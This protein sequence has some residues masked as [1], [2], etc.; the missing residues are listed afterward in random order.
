MTRRPRIKPLDLLIRQIDERLRQLHINVDSLD[1]REK[2]MCLV[3]VQHDLDD[4]GVSTMHYSGMQPKGRQSGAA[5]ERILAYF[6]S[7]P[8]EV[9]AGDELRVVSGI[10]E[11]GRRIRELRREK[12][13]QIASG[14]SSDAFSGVTLK[15]DQYM[16]VS[17]E[18]DQDAARRWHIVNRIRR[19]KGSTRDRILS[20]LQENVGVV[21]TTEELAYVAK[22][23][24]EFGRRIR[25]LRTEQGY[26]IA[27]RFTG[28]PDLGVGQYVLEHVDRQSDPHDRHI[29]ESVQKQVYERDRNRCL[30]CGWMRSSWTREDPRSLEL[31]HIEHHAE[32]GV[33]DATNLVVLCSRCHD[34]VHAG[35]IRIR[36][37]D[38]QLRFE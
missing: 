8:G 20:Y 30:S 6:T 12:G 26:L 32:G 35:R 22:D 24:R 19:S 5:R 14:A 25:E 27:T 2:V 28:R 7:Y 10:S 21:V 29:P 36:R 13:Y 18:P 15:P 23:A 17:R 4:L 33:N 9:I 34:Q 11:Y 16:L 31:H 37:D 38:G 3:A 1:L